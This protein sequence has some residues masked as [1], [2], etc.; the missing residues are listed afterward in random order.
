M[1]V[2]VVLCIEDI[3]SDLGSAMPLC[4]LGVYASPVPKHRSLFV[5]QLYIV[6]SLL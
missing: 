3:N 1:R 4:A 2:W 6:F 5:F